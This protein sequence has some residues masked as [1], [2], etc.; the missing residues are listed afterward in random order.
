MAFQQFAYQFSQSVARLK[1]PF[2][3]RAPFQS[4]AISSKSSAG[5]VAACDVA[6]R[7]GNGRL[8]SG[9]AGVLLLILA[10]ALFLL[11]FVVRGPEVL[12]HFRASINEHGCSDNVQSTLC[13]YNGYF[14][15]CLI[16]DIARIRLKLTPS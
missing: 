7:L 1:N 8:I 16:K 12:L 11:T 10:I 15:V 6:Y 3:R 9:R 2:L 5:S 4:E 13:G 14:Q